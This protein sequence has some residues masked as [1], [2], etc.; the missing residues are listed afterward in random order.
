MPK[1]IVMFVK[2]VDKANRVVGSGA[3]RHRKPANPGEADSGLPNASRGKMP[4]GG[5]PF[6]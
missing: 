1:A 5:L 2:Y 6:Q 3:S 4:S